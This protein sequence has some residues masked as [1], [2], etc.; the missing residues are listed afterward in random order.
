[1]TCYHPIPAMQEGGRVYL[2]R[3][4]VDTNLQ[5][6]CGTCIGCRQNRAMHWALRCHLEAQNHLDTCV[7]TL[8]YD[9]HYLPPTIR[10][11]DLQLWLKRLR[12]NR[13]IRY[14]ACGE[15]GEQFGRP[16]YH[17]ILFGLNAETK[18]IDNAWQRGITRTD[19]A[20]IEA[21]NYITSYTA[22]KAG[23]YI[24]RKRLNREERLDPETGE[25]YTWEAPF[26]IM[27]RRP[28]LG[29]HA[30][31]YYQSWAL[32]AI[33]N[34]TKLNVP[35]FY[36]TAWEQ[37]SNNTE[38]EENEYQKYKHALQ[39]HEHQLT[40]QQLETKEKIHHA[41]QKLRSALRRYE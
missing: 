1:M 40:E 28:G 8:T 29:S 27:S 2:G 36:K 5:L 34:G 7:T 37:L 6:P 24:N 10:R 19:N 17:A 14:Y 33:S 25:L 31:R 21:I 41:R 22:K 11:A 13:K 18:S 30:K 38:K 16:H 4:L 20:S 26:Q 23:W 32:Y 9:D 35:R 15:Y 3:P 12:K 39:R